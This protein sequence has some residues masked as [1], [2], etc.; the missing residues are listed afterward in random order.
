MTDDLKEI[1][2]TTCI[3]LAHGI[4]AFSSCGPITPQIRNKITKLQA[5]LSYHCTQLHGSTENY[6]RILSL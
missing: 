2:E 6:K 3:E 1:L 4:I 5:A